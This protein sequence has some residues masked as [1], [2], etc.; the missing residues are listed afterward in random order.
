MSLELEVFAPDHR[1]VSERVVSLQAADASGRFGLR[2]GHEDF[3][4]VL[5]PCVMRYQLEAG[6]ERFAAVDGGV[7]LLEGGRLSIAT[8]DAVVADRLDQVADAAAAMLKARR[9]KEQA[10]RSGF[11]ELESTLLRELRKAVPRS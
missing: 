8:R 4:T 6:G 7:L 9:E 10:A 3:L 11:A 1:V 2:T 5:V